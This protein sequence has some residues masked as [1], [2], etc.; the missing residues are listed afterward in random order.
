MALGGGASGRYLELNEVWNLYEKISGFISKRE[1]RTRSSCSTISDV[2]SYII[3]SEK[4]LE[5]GNLT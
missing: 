3:A 1:I 5:P 4:G 2:L